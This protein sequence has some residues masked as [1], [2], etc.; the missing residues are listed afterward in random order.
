MIGRLS[1]TLIQKQP[2]LLMIDVHGVGY[3]VQAPM[4]T[5]YQLPELEQGVVLL[6]HMVVREDAQLLYGFYSESERLLFKS[7]IKV[8]GVGPKLALTILSGISADEF[9][10]VVKNNDE[11]GLVR[12][13]GIGKK[14]AQR[15]IV[16]MRDRLDDWQ[17]DK[18]L[19]SA[20]S[21]TGSENIN[22]EQDI[23]KEA[24]SALIALGYKPAEASKMINQLDK[25]QQSSQSLIK[26]ALKNTV[27]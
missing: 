20:E 1:G 7:L 10:Q 8:N 18:S 13:P 12:L 17:A 23:I 9:V 22:S 15:L 4:S 3:E 27:R 25:H 14:T 26:Q 2:P 11:S 16:E 21:S 5:F 24:T 19:D 6:T